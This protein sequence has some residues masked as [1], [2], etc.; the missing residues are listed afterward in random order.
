MPQRT[1]APV[2]PACQQWGRLGAEYG[3]LGAGDPLEHREDRVIGRDQVSFVGRGLNRPEC[4]IAH[5]SGYLFAPDWTGQGGVSIIEPDGTVRRLLAKGWAEPLRPNGIALLAG[6]AFLIAHLGEENGGVFR[7][8]PDGAVTPVLTEVD[9][10]PLPPTNFVHVDAAGRIW[11][12]VSTRL[13]PRTLGF[14]ADIADGFI[15]SI[16]DGRAR[17]VAD[18]LGYTNECCV[19]PSGKCL[20]V[21]ETFGRR[22]SA[23]DIQ[24]DG[25]LTNRR[26]V[27]TFGTGTFPDGLAFDREGCVWVTSVV[28]NRLLR[29]EPGG[30]WEV[31]L[32]DCDDAHVAWAEGAYLANQMNRE[33][34]ATAG[35]SLL[36]NLSSI[37][38]GGDDMRTGY[39]GCHFGGR[40]AQVD[41][42]VAGVA[43][44]HWNAELGPIAS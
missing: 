28:S 22:M 25:T 16:V 29:I 7:L 10:R 3:S 11:I 41:L 12:T 38:F 37:A 17:I 35:D 32:Q 31:V 36:G 5:K 18:G 23:F 2:S 43:Q 44:P 24:G 42:P 33:H 20:F 6:G 9:G 26:V 21:N 13:H 39:F 27:A 19:D 34:L 40:I 14:R 8:D 30:H 1:D 4:V 15:V